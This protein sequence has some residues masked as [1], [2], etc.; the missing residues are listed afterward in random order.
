[1]A[2]EVTDICGEN[3]PSVR[4]IVK[5]GKT[6]V[7]GLLSHLKPQVIAAAHGAFPDVLR[8]RPHPRNFYYS[9]PCHCFILLF[10]I[11]INL[12]VPNL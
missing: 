3:E 12:T 8:E 5:K 7:P 11:V 6:P 1:M 4:D 9:S 10:I 2:T